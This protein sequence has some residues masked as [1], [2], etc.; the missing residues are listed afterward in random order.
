MIQKPNIMVATKNTGRWIALFTSARN[1]KRKCGMKYHSLN[2]HMATE[3]SK[4]MVDEKTP[5]KS[6]KDLAMWTFKL[7]GRL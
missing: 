5:T 7:C 3:Y 2:R 4:T 6:A 1:E